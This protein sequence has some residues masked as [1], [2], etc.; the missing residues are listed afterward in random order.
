MRSLTLL[1]L[2][3]PLVVH[4]QDAPIGVRRNPS[5]VVTKI[6]RDNNG[7]RDPAQYLHLDS[8][9][10]IERVSNDT[11]VDGGITYVKVKVPGPLCLDPVLNADGK[12]LMPHA[13]SETRPCAECASARTQWARAV[14]QCDY[15]H[16]E[17]WLDKAEYEKMTDEHVRY[18]NTPTLG[19]MTLPW[20][21][22]FPRGEKAP[23]VDGGFSLSASFGWRFR[24][25]TQEPMFLQP[26][27]AAGFRGL[28]YTA[29][30]NTAIAGDS[31]SSGTALTVAGGLLFEWDRKQVGVL[32]GTDT[33]LGDTS[34]DY[35]YNG[36]PWLCFTV[37]YAL[38]EEKLDVK[39]PSND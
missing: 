35:V 11:V 2:L 27:V 37:G 23:I 13:S 30:N 9:V 24:L 6:F 4:A 32:L 29:A 39:G 34:K 25:S 22:R 36:A 5:G 1:S 21:Y 31:T 33:G 10:Y 26:S 7:K 38:F 8:R 20:V 15:N 3:F 28:N 19:L 18:Q 12:L 17:F 14:N 16:R